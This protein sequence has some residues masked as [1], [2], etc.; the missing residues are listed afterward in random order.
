MNVQIHFPPTPTH[1]ILLNVVNIQVIPEPLLTIFLVMESQKRIPGN[2][3]TKILE[4]LPQSLISPN[5]FAYPPSNKSN[6]FE[7]D[8]SNFD[9]ENFVL[10]H[11][12]IDWPNILKLD[13][14]NANS[15]TNSIAVV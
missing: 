9:E 7:R 15:A 6:V 4:H 5:T 14:K 10:D 2:I 12:D 13:K 11:F 1:H 8:W 3:A